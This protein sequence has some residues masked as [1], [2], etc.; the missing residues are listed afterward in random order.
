MLKF[1]ERQYPMLEVYC[2]LTV[3]DAEPNLTKTPGFAPVV[4]CQWELTLMHLC[5]RNS[6]FTIM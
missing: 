1:L 5:L 2:C 4:E 3:E 6:L